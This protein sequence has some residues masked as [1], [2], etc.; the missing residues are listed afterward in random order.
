MRSA[1][2]RDRDESPSD[3]SVFVR[4]IKMSSIRFGR[5]DRGDGIELLDLCSTLANGFEENDSCG[6]G[7]VEAVGDAGHG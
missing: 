2:L 4:V 6:D 7:D 3:E 1:H 5:G